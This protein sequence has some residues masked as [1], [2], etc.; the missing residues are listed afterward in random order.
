MEVS[1]D[2]QDPRVACQVPQSCCP[3]ALAAPLTGWELGEQ[4]PT[5]YLHEWSLGVD[6]G[7]AEESGRPEGQ[8][9]HCTTSW[10]SA[11]P[12]VE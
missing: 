4:P 12:S 9:P 11:L 5:C 8:V 3:E 7:C 2:V 1:P 10:E 6:M